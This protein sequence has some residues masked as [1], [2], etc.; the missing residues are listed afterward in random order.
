M[1]NSCVICLEEGILIKYN[2]CGNYFV[3][4][5]CLNKWKSNECFICRKN[6]IEDLDIESLDIESQ[7]SDQINDIQIINENSIMINMKNI[8]SG[9]GCFILIS[10][11]IYLCKSFIHI[12]IIRGEYKIEL[13]Y[14]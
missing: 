13:Y 10:Y 9:I 7:T 3:H 14:N 6:L 8:C 1:I 2:H 12:K 4:Q 5:K 11:L